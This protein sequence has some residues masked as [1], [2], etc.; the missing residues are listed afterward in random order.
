[1]RA[2]ATESPGR[3]RPGISQDKWDL[4]IE[5]LKDGGTVKDVIEQTGISQTKAYEVQRIHKMTLAGQDEGHDTPPAE[6]E[7]SAPGAYH[8]ADPGDEV[9]A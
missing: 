9:I 5:I 7:G 8:Q 1:M 3:G 2:P 6:A 4:A